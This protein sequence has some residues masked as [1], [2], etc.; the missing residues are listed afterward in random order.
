MKTN[1]AARL[2]LTLVLA[3]TFALFALAQSG[4]PASQKF[5]RE[6]LIE[7]Y[8]IARQALEEGHSGIYRY[9]KKADLDRVFD[10]TLKSIDRPMDVFEFYRVLAPAVAAIKC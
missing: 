10:A 5:E 8:Q 7:D 2:I 3:L 1:A 9:T 6:K 4:Q